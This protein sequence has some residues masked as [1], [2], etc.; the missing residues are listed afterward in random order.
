MKTISLFPVETNFFNDSTIFIAYNKL[1]DGY[2]ELFVFNIE[3]RIKFN[4]DI[5]EFKHFHQMENSL[6]FFLNI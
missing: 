3:E 5:V 6:A 1:T 4:F 2:K